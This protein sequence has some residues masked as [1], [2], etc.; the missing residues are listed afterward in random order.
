MLLLGSE[1]YP[2]EGEYLQFICKNGGSINATTA[3]DMTMF[4]FDTS[5]AAFPTALDMFA[6]FFIKPLFREDA[7]DRFVLIFFDLILIRKIQVVTFN[8]VDDIVLSIDR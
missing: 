7:I 4:R 6:N 3:V 5:Q 1:K 2:K 8:H